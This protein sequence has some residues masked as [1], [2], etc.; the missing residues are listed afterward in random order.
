MPDSYSRCSQ[1]LMYTI[2]GH[3]LCICTFKIKPVLAYFSQSSSFLNIKGRL[4]QITNR[5][6]YQNFS[7]GWDAATCIHNYRF[8]FFVHHPLNVRGRGSEG[9]MLQLPFTTK[10]FP[11]TIPFMLGEEGVRG[12]DATCIDN[13]MFFVHHP[14][15]VR[16]RENEG[17]MLQLVLTTKYFPITIPLMLGGEG[18]RVVCCKLCLLYNNLI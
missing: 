18:V 11:S 2:N 9:G 13:Y 6:S 8:M 15:D 10:C 16:R 3:N 5:A 12:N 7:L 1:S 17:G 14:L 4:L